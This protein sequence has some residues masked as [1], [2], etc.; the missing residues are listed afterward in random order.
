MPKIFRRLRRLLKI[1]WLLPYIEV[2]HSGQLTPR[3]TVNV[4][5]CSRDGRIGIYTYNATGAGEAQATEN[6]RALSHIAGLPLK[7][8]R[9]PA[10]D[11]AWLHEREVTDG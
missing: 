1:V 9:R 2:W 11:G 7:D 6:S 4:S 5:I 8:I 10:T 3:P